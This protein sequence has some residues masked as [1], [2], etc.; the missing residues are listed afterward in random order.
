MK[1]EYEPTPTFAEI[2][3]RMSKGKGLAAKCFLVFAYLRSGAQDRGSWEDNKSTAYWGFLMADYCQSFWIYSLWLLF[4]R[5]WM[6]MALN[7]FDGPINAAF[8]SAVQFLDMGLLLYFRPYVSRKT[9]LTETL[10]SITNTLSFL[11]ISLPIIVGPDFPMPSW[12][13]DYTNMM[14]AT[15]GTVFSAFFALSTPVVMMAK[16]L[17]AMFGKLGC[18]CLG[19]S[20]MAVWGQTAIVSNLE[21]EICDQL[22]DGMLNESDDQDDGDSGEQSGTDTELIFAGGMLLGG[23]AAMTCAQHR[24]LKMSLSL[25][26]DYETFGAPFSTRRKAFQEQ[27]V[28]DISHA[29]GLLPKCFLVRRISVRGTLLEIAIVGQNSYEVGR[30]LERQARDVD[31]RLRHGSLT[32]HVLSLHVADSSALS[33]AYSSSVSRTSSSQSSHASHNS[34]DAEFR[35][36]SENKTRVHI[37]ATHFGSHANSYSNSRSSSSA[38]WSSSPSSRRAGGSTQQFETSSLG[39]AQSQL[40]TCGCECGF[41]GTHDEVAEHARHCSKSIRKDP[42]FNLGSF[43]DYT[44]SAS[45]LLGMERLCIDNLYSNI[46]GLRCTFEL[47]FTHHDY[48]CQR[49]RQPKALSKVQRILNHR[50]W[51]FLLDLILR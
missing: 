23:A 42:S 25:D 24:G 29:S 1:F 45:S 21:D 16:G 11:A 44:S 36:K 33:S 39:I 12:M 13:G 14:L 6:S 34:V 19:T 35:K 9:E 10:G 20:G 51:S 17:R 18:S 2:R 22:E 41:E 49:T 48:L 15:F 38:S 40:Y 47:T 50:T 43:K 32:R 26:V 46:L 31:S 8:T 7:W 5:L 4:K 37:Q 3:R 30:M 27:V 28:K